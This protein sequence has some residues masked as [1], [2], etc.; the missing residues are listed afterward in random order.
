MNNRLI[1]ESSPY[2]LSHARHLID[3]YPWCEKAFARARQENKPVF[4]SIGYS[5]CH[6]CHVM[7][8]ESF[9]DKGI[10]R[11]LNENFISVKVDR[12]ERPDLDSIYMEVCQS[13]TGSGGWPM[14]I[15][16]TPEKQPFFAGTYFPKDGW[17]GMI[18]FRQLLTA[19][20][21]KWKEDSS[22]LI[23]SARQIIMTL[24][25]QNAI[26]GEINPAIL[27]KAV[28]QFSKT[29][30]RTY[31]GFGD[32]P[33]FPTPHNLIFLMDNYTKTKNES[34]LF[35]AET[36]L[37]NMYQGGLFDHVGYGFSRYSTDREYQ[38]PHF[39][40]M[41]YDN[42]LLIMA[43]VKAYS[44]TGDNFY[45]Y[46]AE[47]T[48]DYV[49]REMQSPEG[50]FY[51][52]QDADSEGVE[53]RFYIFTPNEIK[54][55]LGEEIGDAFN[56]CYGITPGGN[57]EGS[58]I[59]HLTGKPGD[60]KSFEKYLPALREYR[61]SRSRLSLDD[62]ILTSWNGLMIAALTQ[63]ARVSDDKRYFSAVLKCTDFLYEKMYQMNHLYVSYRKG[64]R[65]VS[66]YLDDYAFMA[67]G[68]L[69]LYQVTNDPKHLK[70]AQNLCRQAITDFWD[71]ENRGFFLSGLNNEELI[72]QTKETHDGALPSG[73]SVMAHNLVRLFHMTEEK[74]WEIIAKR[75]L[76]FLAGSAFQ[77]PMAHSFYL[78]ALSCW[79]YPKHVTI[80]LQKDEDK[81]S[82]LKNI[83][84]DTII[85]ILEHPTEEYKLLENRTTYYVCTNHTCMPPSNNMILD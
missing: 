17:R 47:K 39:E 75:Q 59:P 66:G 3:W 64:R 84:L 35:M 72:L 71:D 6:W 40:K 25:R 42:A 24:S 62:K 23:Q 67:F 19:I 83:P 80:V 82:I 1:N 15:F 78:L 27:E 9:E 44:V 20:S 33:K 56:H 65:G 63:L 13:L 68:I 32:A 61:K 37:K 10:A 7:A 81:A 53:G 45:L 28:K 52:A 77:V 46:V 11:L 21:K 26:S 30:D 8:R 48:G 54:T 34:S 16:L 74:E 76:E 4:L 49:L 55:V 85:T 5:T 31:G 14:T 70:W 36:T 58:S 43:Y 22:A 18:G 12:E 51:T 41:L 79:L 29:F 73:N 69:E 50:G 57:F 60:E 2:L 38:I